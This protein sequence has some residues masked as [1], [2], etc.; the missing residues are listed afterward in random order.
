[1]R[2]EIIDKFAILI[3][4]AFGLVAAL[5]WNDAIKGFLKSFNLEHYGPWV[6][7]CIITVAAVLITVIIG[8]IA[9]RAKN[10][11][12]EKY[13]C[14]PLNKIAKFQKKKKR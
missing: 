2:S 12:L 4:S 7:A 5:A 10:M 3:T 6:Y 14:V 9:Q 1:M 11:N 13:A 8:W